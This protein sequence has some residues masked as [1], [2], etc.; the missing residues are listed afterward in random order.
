MEMVTGGRG[1]MA[2][3]LD[4]NSP[5]FEPLALFALKGVQVPPRMASP[6]E[7]LRTEQGEPNPTSTQL[8]SVVV[9]GF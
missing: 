5:D 7:A 6:A 3:L 1:V 4:P 8:S 2:G 9:D